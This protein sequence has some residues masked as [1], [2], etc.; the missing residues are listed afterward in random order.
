MGSATSVET[1][2]RHHIC[3]YHVILI[4]LGLEL[5]LYLPLQCNSEFATIICVRVVLGTLFAKVFAR[6]CFGSKGQ[7]KQSVFLTSQTSQLSLSF[8]HNRPLIEDRTT[9]A[10]QPLLPCFCRSSSSIIRLTVR[11]VE[12]VHIDYSHSGLDR[13]SWFLGK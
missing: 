11:S 2:L 1:I 6:P 4:G 3:I 5:H 8:L 7:G 10:S 13:D 9:Q 12:D